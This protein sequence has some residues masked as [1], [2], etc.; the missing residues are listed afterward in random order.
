MLFGSLI[1]IFLA[2]P[3]IDTYGL[4]P[5]AFIQHANSTSAAAACFADLCLAG[6]VFMVFCWID[7]SRRGAKRWEFW[8]TAALLPIGLITSVAFY[9]WRREC[10]VQA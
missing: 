10:A 8:V 3:H 6:A 1:P 7:I 5:L 9:L 4:S 2:S